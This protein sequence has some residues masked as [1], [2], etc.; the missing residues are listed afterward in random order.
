MEDRRIILFR[1]KDT[2]K[3]GLTLYLTKEEAYKAA[4]RL[5]YAGRAVLVQHVVR[6]TG[7][8]RTGVMTS[9]IEEAF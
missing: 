9:R 7:R 2:W 3:P 5:S 6:F 1:Y 4:E 8:S